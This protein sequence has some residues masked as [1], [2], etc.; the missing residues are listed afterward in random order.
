M[1]QESLKKSG[2]SIILAAIPASIYYFRYKQSDGIK[3]LLGFILTEISPYIL[4]AVL[5]DIS[6]KYVFFSIASLY[7]FYDIGYL[8]ND[9]K[10]YKYSDG[11]TLR[12]YIN[13]INYKTFLYVRLIIIVLFGLLLIS[14]GYKNTVI[15]L[16]GSLLLL[17]VFLIHNNTKKSIARSGTFTLLNVSKI[18][19]R[20]MSMDAKLIFY[21]ISA[22]PFLIIKYLHYL[23]EKRLVTLPSSGTQSLTLALYAGFAA[24]FIFA[25][26]RIAAVTACYF[27]VHN[28]QVVFKLAEDLKRKLFNH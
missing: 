9:I 21:T 13:N 22:I 16:Y 1:R 26:P 6:L 4:I 8:D 28:K 24:P 14:S 23:N 19:L 7:Y 10:A 27:L 25:E 15:S 17:F 12:S 2:A 20:L 5:S 18:V 11:S 3:A